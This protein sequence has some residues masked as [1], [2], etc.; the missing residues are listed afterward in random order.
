MLISNGQSVYALNFQKTESS[1]ENDFDNQ[2]LN[3]SFIP[4]E[5]N[6]VLSYC[7]EEPIISDQKLGNETF[8]KIKITNLSQ[9]EIHGKPILPFK[10]IQILLPPNTILDHI[11]LNKKTKNMQMHNPILCYQQSYQAIDPHLNKNSVGSN[12]NYPNKDFEI[13]GTETLRGYPI[14]ILNLYPV[15]YEYDSANIIVTSNISL[16][17]FFNESKQDYQLLRNIEQ[18]KTLISNR[19][20]NPS[21]VPFYDSISLTSLS[22]EETIY[23]YII[24]TNEELESYFEP[25]V[26]YKQGYVSSKIVNLTYISSNF[27]GRDLQEKIREFI[28]YAYTYWQTE[29]ILLGGDVSIIPYRGMWGH[30]IDHEGETLHNENIPADLYYA[31]L[32]GSWDADGDYLYGE[33]AMN[34]TEDEADFFAEVYVGRAPVETKAEVAAFIN[35][36]IT[37]ETTEKPESVL[38]HQSGVNSRNNPDSTVIPEHCAEWIPSN[39]NIQKLYQINQTITSEMWMSSFENDQFI[40]E[41]TGNGAP[42]KYYLTWPTNT[43]SAYESMSVL[44]NNFFPI[45]TSV[46]CN[47]GAFDR[48]D[49]IAET[50]LLNPY[51]G[52]SACLFNSRM[53]FT[54]STDAHKYSGE[55]IEQQFY[56]LFHM[57]TKNIGKI[58]QFAKEELLVDALLFPAYRWCYYTINLFGDPEMPVFET[59]Q[60]Y[61]NSTTFFVDDDY[62]QSTSGW[63]ITHFDT[64]NKGINAASDWDVI[65]V[66]NGVYNE[67]ITIRKSVRLIGENKHKTIIDGANGLGTLRISADRIKMSNFTIRNDRLSSDS[68]R[69]FISAVNY[70][71]ISDCIISDNQL[72][73][74]IS[75]AN[76]IFLINNIF[77]E[78]QQSIFATLKT[79][80]IY[81]N[82]NTFSIDFIDG[83]GIYAKGNGRYEMC[84][85]TFSSNLN[86]NN[87]TCAIFANGQTMIDS[88]MIIG[89]TIGLWLYDGTHHIKN[90]IISHNKQTGVYTMASSVFLE[91]NTI[92]NN[93]NNFIGNKYLLDFEPGGISM[94]ASSSSSVEIK[95]NEIVKNRGFGLYLE[96]FM[97]FNNVVSQNDFIDNSI[98]VFFRNSRCRWLANYWGRD[99]PFPKIIIGVYEIGNIFKIPFIQFDVVPAVSIVN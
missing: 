97:G 54:S 76:N 29:F 15:Q 31:G 38:L 90:N 66:K 21:M 36:V 37:F 71:T 11:R 92:E 49:C 43:F 56:H 81:I 24:I 6:M 55:F 98:N 72:G 95:H 78:N 73:I 93:G 35:K 45:H 19:V 50:I 46:A 33:D 82:D 16:S 7:F 44:E 65:F 13:V 23:N 70:V 67:R 87:F 3:Y 42:D 68:C 30:A 20:D 99:N 62:N 48:D 64:I 12:N 79:K 61:L 60:Y 58:N 25:L 84:N 5:N 26:R 27:Y 83:Y 28:R 4:S 53:G 91:G 22:S 96:G 89:C 85:N 94:Y 74:Y 41:H 1:L 57:G 14:L 10:T 39:Y 77:Q 17:F 80:N 47:S 86:F 88:N 75:E 59:R 8:S 51:G 63:N 18:D 69:I 34:S 32:D 9:L 40:V 52:A 2:C